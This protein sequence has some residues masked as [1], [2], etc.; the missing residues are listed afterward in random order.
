MLI[1]YLKTNNRL[2]REGDEFILAFGSF[3]GRKQAF[4]L[5]SYSDTLI[6]IIKVPH[7]NVHIK[8]S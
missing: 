3:F 7:Q 6:S 2:G 8:C 4:I 5:C 1:Y